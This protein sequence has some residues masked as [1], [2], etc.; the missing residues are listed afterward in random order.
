MQWG[1]SVREG[2]EDVKWANRNCDAD[3]VY[4]RA[5]EDM[6]ALLALVGDKGGK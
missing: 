2:G 3:E 4:D 1:I 6:R 5:E